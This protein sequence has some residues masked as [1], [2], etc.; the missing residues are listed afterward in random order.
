MSSNV[1]INSDTDSGFIVSNDDEEALELMNAEVV[2]TKHQVKL[3]L[4][5]KLIHTLLLSSRRF[6]DNVQI[7]ATSFGLTQ[8]LSG[9]GAVDVVSAMQKLQLLVLTFNTSRWC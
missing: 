5:R 4:E 7:N 9:A 3:T 6:T 8:S 1:T 2:V